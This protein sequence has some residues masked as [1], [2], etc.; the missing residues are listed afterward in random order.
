MKIY[1]AEAPFVDPAESKLVAQIESLMP[2]FRSTLFPELRPDV[3]LQDAKPVLKRVDTVIADFKEPNE[4]LRDKVLYAH[5]I[6]KSVLVGMSIRL[7]PAEVL[8]EI[9]SPPYD[10]VEKRLK[11]AYYIDNE[12]GITAIK[13]QRGG[14]SKMQLDNWLRS[15]QYLKNRRTG[16]PPPSEGFRVQYQDKR[17]HGAELDD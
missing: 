1:F 14:L 11:R 3:P 2:E 9:A 6:G 15:Q 17:W 5:S 16:A 12:N 13:V 4:L 7:N 10:D 8:S